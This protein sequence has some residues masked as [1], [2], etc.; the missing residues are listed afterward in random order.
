MNGYERRQGE[1][2]FDWDDFD[3][4]P[5]KPPV[6]VEMRRTVGD[7]T[8]CRP[9]LKVGAF[10][11]EEEIAACHITSCGQWS[12]EPKEQA[13]LFVGWLGVEDV[14]QGRGLGRYALLFTMKAAQEIGYRHAAISTS[15]RNHRAFV[16]YSNIGFHVTDMTYGWM[17]NRKSGREE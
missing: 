3:V 11:G 7:E 9:G 14:Y 13:R 12:S 10:L 17:K 15:V 5:G 6:E 8:E 4:D 1:I 16:F 2:F